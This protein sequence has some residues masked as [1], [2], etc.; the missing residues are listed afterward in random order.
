MSLRDFEIRA[1]LA[2]QQIK[3]LQEQ[4]QFLTNLKQSQHAT[5]TIVEKEKKPVKTGAAKPEESKE[6]AKIPFLLIKDEAFDITEKDRDAKMT[7]TICDGETN[8]PF[9]SAKGIN[10]LKNN[11]NSTQYDIF[12]DTYAKCGTTLTIHMVYQI[13]VVGLNITPYGASKEDMSD[14]WNAVPWIDAECSQQLLTD[15]KPTKL[16]Q[17]IEES[18]KLQLPRIWKTHAPWVNLPV[19][20]IDEKSKIIHVTRNPKDVICSY[21]SFFKKEPLVKYKGDFDTMFD[22]FCDGSVV[23]SNYFEFE[24][25]WWRA[26]KQSKYKNQI[27]WLSF[28]DIVRFP[29]KQIQLVADFLKITLTQQQ[30][31]KISED[32]SFESMKE[33]ASKKSESGA[34]ILMNQGQI[35][36]WRKMLSEKQSARIDRIVNSRFANSGLEF[37]YGEI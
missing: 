22:W 19:H 20:T 1:D 8:P 7:V 17:F 15:E 13:Y 2:E 3:V 36:R 34:A 11:F 33:Q 18:N 28:E 10:W 25:S 31:A 24:L 26:A 4:L 30:I 9:I 14:P 32:I 12:V 16:L 29:E 27:L 23:H 6:E 35:G 21:Y 5:T 37:Y